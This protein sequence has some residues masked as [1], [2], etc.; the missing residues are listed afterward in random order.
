M[1]SIEAEG[2][3]IDEAIDRALSTLR[4]ARDRVEIEIVSNATR[5]LFGLGGRKAKIRATTLFGPIGIF[6]M[7]RY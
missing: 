5:G 6:V 3:T 4:V 2:N 1:R 7:L